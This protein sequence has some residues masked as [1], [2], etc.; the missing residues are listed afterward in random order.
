M[1]DGGRYSVVIANAGDVDQETITD[2]V[3][4]A[5]G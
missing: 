4:V 3:T 2:L 5:P 1:I